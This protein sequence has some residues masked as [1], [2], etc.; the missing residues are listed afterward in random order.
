MKTHT[1][2]PW[3]AHEDFGRHWISAGKGKREVQIADVSDIEVGDGTGEIDTDAAT[4]AANARLI[5]AAPD[6]LA[7][8]VKALNALSTAQADVI[9]CGGKGCEEARFF[10]EPI[11][12]LRRTL[13]RTRG[14]EKEQRP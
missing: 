9:D 14:A 6:L 1:A 8:C 11:R 2:G 10:D 5:A 7:A 3:K 4:T 12:T 13:A